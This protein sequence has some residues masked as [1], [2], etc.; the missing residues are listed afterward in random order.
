MSHCLDGYMLVSDN[1]EVTAF[2]M[3]IGHTPLL[4][5]LAVSE[6]KDNKVISLEAM[7]DDETKKKFFKA[8]VSQNNHTTNIII[9]RHNNNYLLD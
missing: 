8:T 2:H 3:V 5:Y 6:G 1:Q 9:I 4:I 7:D